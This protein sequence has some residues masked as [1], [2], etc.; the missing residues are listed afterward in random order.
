MI[1]LLIET[2]YHTVVL[3]MFSVSYYSICKVNCY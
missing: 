2:N 1:L 3:I